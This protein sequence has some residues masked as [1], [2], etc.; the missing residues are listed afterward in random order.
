MTKTVDHDD[1]Y[2]PNLVNHAKKA[3]AHHSS[4]SEHFQGSFPLFV[5][6]YYEGFELREHDHEYLEIVYVMS[7]EGYHYVGEHMERASKGCLYILPIGTSHILR[8]R[9]ASSKNSLMVYNL[10]IRTEF[11]SELQRWLSPYSTTAELWSIF[12]GKP[13][14]HVMVQ[15]KSMKFSR[16]FEQLHREFEEKQPGYE[17]S[18]FSILL[19]LAVQLGRQLNQRANNNS[20]AKPSEAR[21]SDMDTVVDYINQ[22][23]ADAM[24]LNQLAKDI[25]VSRRHFIR[26]FQQRI[27]MGFSEYLQHKRMELACQLLM[28][29]DDKIDTIAKSTGYRDIT[30]FRRVF[31]KLMGTSPSHYRKS[32]D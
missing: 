9:D 4:A 17:A 11:V 31:R 3:P 24:T 2:N 13:G 18:M 21:R 25:G 28:E 27:G 7:G 12:E 5:N 20:E 19:Q 16:S 22:H 10:C 15:D 26:L 29:T 32:I 8:P 30:H 23:I 14:C 1:I 6:R